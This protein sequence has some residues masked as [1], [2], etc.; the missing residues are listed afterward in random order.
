MPF[1]GS[2]VSSIV[3]ELKDKLLNGKIDKVYQP[4]KDELIINIR[5]YKDSFKL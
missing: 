4:E 3:H 5:G 2:V 1:D